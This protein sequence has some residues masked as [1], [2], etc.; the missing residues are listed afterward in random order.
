ME[1]KALAKDL[2]GVYQYKHENCKEKKIY[3]DPH[4]TIEGIIR[5]CPEIQWSMR[6]IEQK[7]TLILGGNEKIGRAHV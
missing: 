6:L 2:P 3:L 7:P 1:E 5:L 4:G